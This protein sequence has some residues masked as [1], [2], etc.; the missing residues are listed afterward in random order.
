MDD[1]LPLK[2]DEIKELIK[3][4]QLSRLYR[5]YNVNNYNTRDEF[6]HNVVKEYRNRESV[7]W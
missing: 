1:P 3:H 6:L 2:F 7:M 5:T 4:M